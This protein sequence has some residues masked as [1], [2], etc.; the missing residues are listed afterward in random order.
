MAN[1]K[2]VRRRIRTVKNI[3][4]ITAAMKMV[5]AAK[6]KKAQL[7]AESARPYAEKMRDVMGNLAKS[8]GEIKHPLLETREEHNVAYLIIGADR[9]LAGS[10]NGNVMNRALR[11]I[12]KRKEENIKLVLIGK[13]AAGFFKK[14]PYETLSTL[15]SVGGDVNFADIRKITDVLRNLFETSQVDAVYLVYAKFIS[16]MTQKPTVVKLLPM[17]APDSDGLGTPDFIFE[18]DAAVLLSKLLPRYLETQVYQSVV[19]SQASEHGARMT[20]MSAATKNAGE[21]ID[22]LT[23]LY[24]KARQAAI[25]K[26][27]TEIVGG[28]EALK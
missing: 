18:P 5:A 7:R 15:E 3:E 16:A 22:N 24:N 26:E 4:K 19:E 11:S 9:G 23:L 13:K 8:V 14:L 21:M 25:T 17:A 12:N 6:L 27:I 28:A 10:Y 1:A 2:D 20:A